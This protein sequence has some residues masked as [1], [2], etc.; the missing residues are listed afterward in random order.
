MHYFILLLQ[1][2]EL[3]RNWSTHYWPLLDHFA[4]AI[5]A[6]FFSFYLQVTFEEIPEP[7]TMLCMIH[8]IGSSSFTPW[9]YPGYF[10]MKEVVE[11]VGESPLS[12]IILPHIHL[13]SVAS[14]RNYSAI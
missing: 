12:I 3:R 8:A 7:I 6:V 13:I 11:E 4:S 2:S 14:S 9:S 1:I 5:A 10:E